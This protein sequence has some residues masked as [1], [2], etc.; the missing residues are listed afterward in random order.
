MKASKLIKCIKRLGGEE[1]RQSGS[2]VRFRLGSC[3]T[4]VP[5]HKGEEIRIGTL[6]GIEEDLEPCL[7][8]G[9]LK[10]WLKNP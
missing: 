6:N 5:N 4:T 8:K 3:F 10:K 1:L 7:G 2:H 9:W